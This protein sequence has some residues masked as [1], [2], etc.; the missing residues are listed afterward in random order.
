[1][2]LNIPPAWRRA[3]PAFLLVLLA[4]LLIFWRTG[5]AMVEIWDRSETFAHAFV[6]PPISLWLIWR[7]RAQLALMA[8]RPAPLVLLLMALV[9]FGWLLGELAAVNS[10]T[11]LAFVALLVLCVPLQ[12]G[13]PVAR[14]LLFPLGFLFFCVPVGEFMMPQMMQWTADFTVMAVRLSGVPVYRE[15]LSF[16]IPSGTWSVVQACSG[17][18]YLIASVMVGVLFAYL[19][20]RS[21]KRRLLFV[22]VSFLLPVL[23][24]WLR[25]YMIVMLGH[26]S[27]NKIATG[28]D[29]I[30][31]GW[32]FFGVVMLLLF[33]IGMRWSEPEAEPVQP[34]AQAAGADRTSSGFAPVALMGLVL[35]ALPA[36]ALHQLTKADPVAEAGFVLEAPDLA[37]KGWQISPASDLGYKTHFVQPR[38][39][40]QRSYA[41]PGAPAVG[42]YVAYYRSQ[43]YASKLIS[44]NNALAPVGDS[45]WRSSEGGVADQS[46]DGR[47][48]SWRTAT[49]RPPNLSQEVG[50]QHL[51]A[52]QIYW[53][54]GRW[55]GSDELAKFYAAL[56]RLTGQGDD[57]AVLVLY[58]DAAQGGEALLGRFAEENFVPIDGWLT[59]VRR[60]GGVSA[61]RK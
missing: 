29:H 61:Q 22:L 23:A 30:I 44:S 37:A 18:R 46:V 43:D 58:A 53:V 47:A 16:V 40:L 52:R 31:Y 26:L 54:A 45:R 20:Y 49:L 27:G 28:V 15:G 11:Q 13:W 41:K 34:A 1:M 51:V 55:T 6:V 14:E 8:P 24:N 19:N 25:A 57:S 21:L 50:G 10:A 9:A 33:M 12:L 2:T 17:I 36:L 4:V 56:S 59:A 39:E 38:G 3:L 35:L 60:S 7:Q 42:V 5:L 32:I 48:L